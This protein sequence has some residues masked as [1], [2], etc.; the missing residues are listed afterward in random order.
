MRL[1]IV[2]FL[3]LLCVKGAWAQQLQ[4]TSISSAGSTSAIGTVHFQST[5]G[6]PALV[7]SAENE[8]TYISQGFQSGKTYF[9]GKSLTQLNYQLYPNPTNSI[10]TIKIEDAEIDHVVLTSITGKQ[11]KLLVEPNGEFNVNELSSGV[12]GVKVLVAGQYLH[13]SKLIVLK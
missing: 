12:Y 7:G 1:F 8:K 4:K 2:A 5:I 11:I 13:V 9:W 10:A 3:G 6:Q